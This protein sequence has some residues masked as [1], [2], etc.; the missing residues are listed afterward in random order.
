[1]VRQIKKTK[2]SNILTIIIQLLS[3]NPNSFKNITTIKTQP[4]KLRT[5][6]RQLNSLNFG[7]KMGNGQYELQTLSNEQKYA[8]LHDSMMII[9]YWNHGELKALTKK[10]ASILYN[11]SNA[12][13][14]LT[15]MRWSCDKYVEVSQS[16]ILSLRHSGLQAITMGENVYEMVH[17]LDKTT[18]EYMVNNAKVMI[19]KILPKKSAYALLSNNCID[20]ISW[21]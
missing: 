15:L 20:N 8:V 2:I 16:N 17:I 4:D 1:L 19:N 12:Y 14:G 18:V 5:A 6:N 3:K 21:V 9:G 10:H 13:D 11:K 7:S